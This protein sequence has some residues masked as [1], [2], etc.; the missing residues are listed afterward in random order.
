[1]GVFGGMFDPPHIGHL[2][3][4]SEVAWQLRL[5]EVRLVVCARPAHRPDGWL[6]AETRLRLV[7]R[8][9]AG[10]PA[11]TV[12]RAEV[13]RPGPSFTVD[14]LEGFARQE[15][16]ASFWLVL[17]PDQLR[18]FDRWRSPE[19][20]VQLARLAAIAREGAGPSGDAGV[21]A[22][23]VGHVD[24]VQMPAIGVSSTMIRRRIDAGE[25][26]GHLLPPGVGDALIDE[27]LSVRLSAIP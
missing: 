25:P 10:N 26:V 19:R 21:P 27:G 1:M 11:L 13:D 20:I 14:T 3:L 18:G 12:S 2:I 4:A 17:G 5:D 24:W 9:V 8:A 7:E 6:P 15:P 16:G 23:A 22:V